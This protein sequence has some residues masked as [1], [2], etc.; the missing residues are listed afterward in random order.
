[1]YV[2]K[3][4]LDKLN[5]EYNEILLC[6]HAMLFQPP[7]DKL[8]SEYNFCKQDNCVLRLSTTPQ[9]RGEYNSYDFVQHPI[10]STTPQFRGEYN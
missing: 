7:L 3:P 9:I 6:S 2:S 10:F 5:D 4:P 1:M 8:N